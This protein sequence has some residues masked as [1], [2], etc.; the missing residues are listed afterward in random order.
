MT[1][2]KTW[3]FKKRSQIQEESDCK[4]EFVDAGALAPHLDFKPPTLKEASCSS[5]KTQE[6]GKAEH[7]SAN[8]HRELSASAAAHVLTHRVNCMKVCPYPKIPG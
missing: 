1:Y 2:D 3:N 8:H 6:L 4:S 7:I 5:Q